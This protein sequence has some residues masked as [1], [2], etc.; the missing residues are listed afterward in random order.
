M[1]R[2]VKK[3]AIVLVAVMVLVVSMIPMVAFEVK[4]Y[5]GD[6]DNDGLV[7]K[8]LYVGECLGK[9]TGTLDEFVN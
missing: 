2:I 5:Y 1:K 7:M 4:R 6:V 8:F 3:I 9:N